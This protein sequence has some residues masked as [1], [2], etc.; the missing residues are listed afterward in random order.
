MKRRA[1]VLLLAAG[2]LADPRTAHALAVYD[3]ANHAQNLLTAVRSLAA[4]RHLSD[5]VAGLQQ[6][7]RQLGFDGSA[8]LATGG[9]WLRTLFANAPGIAWGRTP[10]AVSVG[11][12]FPDASPPAAARAVRVRA[13][14]GRADVVREGW[15]HSHDVQTGVV[16]ESRA[17]ETLLGGLVAASRGAAGALSAA[18]AGNQIAALQVREQLRTQALLAAHQ[19]TQAEERLRVDAA[20]RTARSRFGASIGTG[21]LYT[22]RP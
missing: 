4:V 10:A 7:L 16:E 8:V 12:L 19:R 2:L 14:R 9:A 13:V 20:A 21:N 22:R 1:A 18:Q 3:G 11:N 5:M 15:R 17:S 6:N